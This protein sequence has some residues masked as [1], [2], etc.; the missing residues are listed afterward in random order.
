MKIWS[1]RKKGVKLKG[2]QSHGN[3][4]MC[5]PGLAY[6]ELLKKNLFVRPVHQRE[7]IEGIYQLGFTH[8]LLLTGQSWH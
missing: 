6:P 8:L 3:Q 7:E 2:V 5:P 1:K 4:P